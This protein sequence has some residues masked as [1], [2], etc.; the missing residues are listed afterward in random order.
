MGKTV[1]SIGNIQ[2]VTI[3]AHLPYAR[4]LRQLVKDAT[5]TGVTVN[6]ATFFSEDITELHNFVAGIR[7]RFLPIN[8][9]PAL[10]YEVSDRDYCVYRELRYDGSVIDPAEW[11]AEF[12]SFQPK[13]KEAARAARRKQ[14]LG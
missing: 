8:G 6:P 13:E 14:V 10:A 1:V 4:A 9:E 11:D 7:Y 12:G 2:E 3:P 5:G